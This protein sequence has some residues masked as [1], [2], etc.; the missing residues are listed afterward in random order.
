MLQ[1]LDGEYSSLQPV[2]PEKNA[3]VVFNIECAKLAFNYQMIDFVIVLNEKSGK[4]AY[5]YNVK[6]CEDFLATL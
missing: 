2:Q 3:L 5:C 4:F 1:I 6:E